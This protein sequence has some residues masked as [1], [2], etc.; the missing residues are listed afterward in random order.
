MARM[1]WTVSSCWH[2][3]WILLLV[4]L[5]TRYGITCLLVS[6]CDCCI[7][8]Q[9]E[10]SIRRHI[11]M[12]SW[13]HHGAIMVSSW[14]H[15]D[16]IMVPSWCHHD[17]IMVTPWCHHGAIMVPSRSHHGAIVVF[18][19]VCFVFWNFHFKLHSSEMLAFKFYTG[20]P[21]Y[22]LQIKCW[23]MYYRSV[24]LKIKCAFR[25]YKLYFY[26]C[27]LCNS[28]EGSKQFACGWPEN[29]RSP[30]NRRYLTAGNCFINDL[31]LMAEWEELKIKAKLLR[32]KLWQYGIE[33]RVWNFGA[34]S[35]TL[36]AWRYSALEK[37]NAQWQNTIGS[38]LPLMYNIRHLCNLI[39]KWRKAETFRSKGQSPL[40]TASQLGVQGPILKNSS[41]TWV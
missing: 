13:C 20:M 24:H 5:N 15:H 34:R 14:C 39:F 38:G 25:F 19:M 36:S 4:Y 37:T 41:K 27:F 35:A 9:W 26:N 1:N 7:D 17:A 22:S 21:F 40:N 11:M 2:T 28:S 31:I 12:P 16:A 6:I 10:T 3:F 23:N 29:R 30:E 32:W 33:L 18:L 8:I